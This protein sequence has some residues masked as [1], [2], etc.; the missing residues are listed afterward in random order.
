M[1][2]TVWFALSD[3]TRRKI[4][5]LLKIKDLS[6]GEISDNFSLSKPTI[7]HHLAILKESGIVDSKKEK[8]NIIYKQEIFEEHL[9]PFSIDLVK[10]TLRELGYADFIVKPLPYFRDMEFMEIGWYCLRAQKLE[11]SVQDMLRT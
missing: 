9:I 6:A 5:S 11:S 10:D 8:N 3:K 2:N 7:S 4:I 1:K